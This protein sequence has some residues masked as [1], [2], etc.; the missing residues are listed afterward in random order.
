MRL[1]MIEIDWLREELE[2]AEF[3]G[4]ASSLV[5]AIGGHH[6]DRQI[7][8][9]LLDLRQQLQAIHTRHVDVREN[10]EKRRLDLLSEPIQCLCARGSEKHRIGSLAGLAA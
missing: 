4:A 10:R 7:G 8:E 2:S 3:A 1:Q 5:V 9:P 6:H